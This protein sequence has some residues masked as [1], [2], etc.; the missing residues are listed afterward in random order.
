MALEALVLT[1]FVLTIIRLLALVFTVLILMTWT[2]M[3]MRYTVLMFT[4]II[5]ESSMS[6]VLIHTCRAL[7]YG[8]RAIEMQLNSCENNR[9]TTLLHHSGFVACIPKNTTYTLSAPVSHRSKFIHISL[10][11][12]LFII[13]RPLVRCNIT[14]V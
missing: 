3:A 14:A 13:T 10:P 11:L 9:Y 2:Y 8:A 4:P 7:L 5:N 1:M 6:L 12:L